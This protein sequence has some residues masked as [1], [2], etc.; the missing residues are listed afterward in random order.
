MVPPPPPPPPFGLSHELEFVMVAYHHKGVFARLGSMH[1]THHLS[2]QVANCCPEAGP[3]NHG[4]YFILT[5]LF[6]PYL[7][8]A[9]PI[10]TGQKEQRRMHGVEGV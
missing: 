4:Q 1:W 10:V 2:Q 6:I 7:H 5:I 9:R 8:I 3:G